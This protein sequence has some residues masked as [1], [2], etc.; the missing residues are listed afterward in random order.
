M[1]SDKYNLEA[2]RHYLDAMEIIQYQ[3][4]KVLVWEEE[5]RKEV[6]STLKRSENLYLEM[7]EGRGKTRKEKDKDKEGGTPQKGLKSQI[8]ESFVTKEMLYRFSV[9]GQSSSS[10]NLNI[11][12]DLA[13]GKSLIMLVRAGSEESGEGRSWLAT[14]V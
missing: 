14:G 12:F 13:T 9:A 11:F 3:I 5:M 2:C 6:F 4:G 8:R 10:K 7:T 1:L